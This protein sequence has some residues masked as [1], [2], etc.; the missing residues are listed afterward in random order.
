[1][2]PKRLEDI[3]AA[4]ILHVISNSVRENR[5][6]EYKRDLPGTADSDKKEFLGDVSSFAN[7]S[8]GDVL[9]GI[10]AVDGVPV[11]IAG[12]ANL[13]EDAELLRLEAII[14]GGLD[15]RIP[16]VRLK[17]INGLSPGPVLLIRVPKSWAGPHMVSFKDWSRFY[18]RSSAGK[19]LLD[20]AELR[21][22]FGLSAELP[23]RVRAW[24]D[25]RLAKVLA[26]ETP[27]PLTK[28]G[29]LVLHIIPL[30]SFNEQRWIP[31]VS[32]QG[33]SNA[34]QPINESVSNRRINLDGFLT[35]G[36]RPYDGP[37][38]LETCYCQVFSTGR[39]E[40]VN[41]DLV[42][43]WNGKKLIPSL[44]FEMTIL[45][46]IARYMKAL[47]QLDV[48]LPFLITMSMLGVRGAALAT[49]QSARENLPPF[50]RDNLILPD[51]LISEPPT[52]LP[53][54]IKPIFDAVWNACGVPQSIN[55]GPDGR[56]N[57]GVLP[58][59]PMEKT[60]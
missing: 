18:S 14:R 17:V 54:A 35:H 4:D 22:A 37:A 41:A 19:T 51:V 26:G 58:D 52:D 34:F 23:G 32:W 40:A 30:A 21:S 46:A 15:P 6:V 28:S 10:R 55:F 20:T 39:L 3:V 8:G 24:R 60:T 50:D 57:R 44:D 43:D 11:E 13:N 9:Y 7:A 25:D 48:Q 36:G 29:T 47:I 56:W 5:T 42:H 49:Q 45:I 16:G 2:I 38:G 53:S 1:M 33:H 12:I 27:T 59:V 31:A